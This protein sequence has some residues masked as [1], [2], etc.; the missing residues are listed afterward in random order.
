MNIF[1][2]DGMRSRVGCNSH[3]SGN[4][5]PVGRMQPR[6]KGTKHFEACAAATKAWTKQHF[7]Y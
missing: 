3:R 4:I 5:F 6:V 7:P 2:V 1:Q